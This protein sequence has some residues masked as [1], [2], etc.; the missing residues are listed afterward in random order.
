M[1]AATKPNW[2]EDKPSTCTIFRSHARYLSSPCRLSSFPSPCSSAYILQVGAGPAGLASALVLAQNGV[3]VRIIDKA[4]TY[5]TG[6][7]GFGI[8]VR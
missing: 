3:Q 2:M 4:D 6:S 7:R 1:F 5:H 8:Q